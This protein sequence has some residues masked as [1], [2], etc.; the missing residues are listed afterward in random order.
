MFVVNIDSNVA[1][2]PYARSAVKT[3]G[4]QERPAGDLQTGSRRDLI[5]ELIVA[6][7]DD[8]ETGDEQDEPVDQQ[9]PD[10]RHHRSE[11]VMPEGVKEA[12]VQLQLSIVPESASASHQR[13]AVSVPR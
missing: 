11:T 12:A 10:D 9:G 13:L 2:K 4:E 5:V 8:H 7:F 3:R 6:D 1:G